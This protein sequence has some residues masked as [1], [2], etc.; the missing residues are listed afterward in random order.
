MFRATSL[1][2]VYVDWKAG[3]QVNFLPGFAH[4]WWSRWQNSGLDAFTSPEPGR[5]RALGIDYI[6]LAPAHRVRT[7]MPA[8]ENARFIVYRTTE[9]G[10]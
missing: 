4:E 10:T 6:V 5:Y 3:G 1:R 2:S 9:P 7:R 8:F